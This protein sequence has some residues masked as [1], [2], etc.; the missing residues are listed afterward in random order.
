MLVLNPNFNLTQSMVPDWT[1][2]HLKE[3]AKKKKI[4]HQHHLTKLGKVAQLI[5]NAH[6]RKWHIAS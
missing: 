3:F 1:T 6:E 5:Y 4:K 2:A